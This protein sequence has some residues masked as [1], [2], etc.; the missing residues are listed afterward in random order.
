MTE[1]K[2][3]LEVVE[4]YIQNFNGNI[5]HYARYLADIL[6][7][8]YSDYI[9]RR[10]SELMS[11]KSGTNHVGLKEEC[12]ANGIPLDKV[13]MYWYKGKS[14]SIK[15]NT[16]NDNNSKMLESLKDIVSSYNPDNLRTIKKHN[17]TT[18]KALNATMSDM[19]V[20]L[21]PNPNGN[22][23]FSYK[24]NES[25][26]KDNLDKVF[27]SIIKEYDTHGKFDLL[28]LDDLGDGLDGWNGFTTRGGHKLDQNM[29]N[30]EMFRV[31]VE[32]KLT[33]IENCIRAGVANEI[34]IRNVSNCNHSGSF[35]K[36]ANMSINMILNRTHDSSVS[37]YTLSKFMEHFKYGDHTFIL[38]HGKDESHMFKG[39]PL[40]LDLKAT[41]FI[42]EYIDHY[43]INTPYIHL[44]KGDLHQVGYQ[45]T[46]KFDYRSF[47][48]FAPPSAYVQHNFGDSYSGYSIQVI[49]KF[50]NE[51]SHC[52]YYFDM[53]KNM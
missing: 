32:G 51:I 17:L 6:K 18:H 53:I 44:S 30:A 25:I 41:K 45:R 49:P 4:K 34:I 31:Y 47:M 29:N 11:K 52:D 50:S 15:T 16:E 48:S 2:I 9:R 33:L 21:E 46:N 3:T 43:G 37:S 35:G 23:L 28:V 1:S 22:S 27:N 10:V 36:I 13:S 7:I 20:G 5:T 38:T 8:E 24:Y 40:V 14:Y 39:L 26:F 42:N 19:H 12:E